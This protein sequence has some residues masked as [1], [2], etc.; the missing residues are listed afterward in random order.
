MPTH[1]TRTFHC[2]GRGCGMV[3]QVVTR[4]PAELISPQHML[5]HHGESLP[6]PMGWQAIA[7]PI[8]VH[9]YEPIGAAQRVHT[10]TQP[11]VRYFCNTCVGKLAAVIEGL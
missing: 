1:D 7:V 5:A 8:V 11:E 2:D 6:H 9:K 4:G 10:V 3:A